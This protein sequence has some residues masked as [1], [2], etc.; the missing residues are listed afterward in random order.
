MIDGLIHSNIEIR[1]DIAYALY[2]GDVKYT[3]TTKP[4]SARLSQRYNKPIQII[5]VLPNMPP[6]HIKDNFIVVNTALAEHIS[7]DDE[8]R[9]ILPMD[10]ADM[11]REASNSE[12]VKACIEKILENQKD[13]FVNVFK[14][15][16]E[17]TLPQEDER[18][19]VIGPRPDLFHYFDNKINQRRD[20]NRLSIPVPDGYIVNS[21]D[22]LIETYVTNFQDRAF[23]ASVNGFS[24][25]GSLRVSSLEDIL[26]SEKLKGKNQFII[27]EQLDLES[28][29]AS[30]GIVANEDE[31]MFVSVSDQIMDGVV[32]GGNIYPSSASIENKKKIEDYTQKIGKFLAANGYRG[33][34]GVD[35]MI[36]KEGQ[37]YF[38]EINPRKIGSAP[39]NIS[40]YKIE[41]P[42][43]TSLPELEFLAVTEGTFGMDISQYNMPQTNW[44][45]RALE[46]HEGQRTLN[47]VPMTMGEEALFRNP[48][49]TILD[50]P[51]ENLIFL[52][53]GRL[54]RV[55][56]TSNADDPRKEIVDKLRQGEESIKLESPQ[57]IYVQH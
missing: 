9:Y 30:L 13:L 35:F 29:P 56:C 21:F 32:Y 46:G 1:P 48:G 10:E 31:V 43:L 26:S 5:N 38:A 52:A 6:P 11:N 51:G 54:A 25:N 40:A 14:S 50:H 33:F 27:S 20:M 19:R 42:Y 15:T 37:L 24:G 12:Y 2:V 57:L 22:E 44:G 36:N 8:Q 39:E 17:M 45:V 41:N 3:D 55:V 34:F 18:I 4:I 47:Y 53:E 7:S 16:P 49:Y 23:V 28:C